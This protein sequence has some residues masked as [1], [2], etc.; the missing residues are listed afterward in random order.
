MDRRE[1]LPLPQHHIPLLG[2]FQTGN[3]RAGQL[4]SETP[5]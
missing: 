3:E 5:R 4:A 1:I 2:Q